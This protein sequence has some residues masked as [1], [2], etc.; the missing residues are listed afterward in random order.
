MTRN[1]TIYR[2]GTAR[3]RVTPDEPLW[4]AGYS[5]RT[6]PARGTLSEL[7]AAA[8]ALQDPEGGTLVIAS[9]DLIAVTKPLAD[10]VYELVA[11]ETGLPRERIV[12]AATHT[13]YGPEFRPDKAV[14]F[15]IPPEFAA[16]IEPTAERMAAALAR[17]IV[18]ALREMEPATLRAGRA[19]AGFA[20]NRRRQGVKFGAPSA[21]DVL[22][23]DVPA[24]S[25]ISED[26]GRQLA[27]VY[28]YACHNTTIPPDDGRYC[29][30][31]AGFAADHLMGD[32]GFPTPLFVAGCGAD[33]NPEPRGSLELSRRYGAELAA[34]ARAALTSDAGHAITGPLRAAFEDVSLPLQPVRRP[35]L[36]Q[37]LAD[38]DPPKRVKA[39]FLLEQLDR[40]ASLI[41]S[42][43]APV[44]AVRIGN[45]LLMIA[46]SGEPVV[47]WSIRFKREFADVAPLVWVAGY[48]ND[49][50][51]YVPTRRIQR[52]GGY[53]G[54][55]ANLW[56]SVPAPFT[57]EVEDAVAAAVS[58]VVGRVR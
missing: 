3:E 28:G 14:F 55:R 19:A 38:D 4:L 23:Q 15:N 46:M 45:E 50:F 1:A 48:C 29:G 51:G 37:M 26:K 57:E 31:W 54:G 40:G 27:I 32:P 7:Y 25:V 58:R 47:D 52:E 43:A 56:S 36:E 49:M 10:R 8:L 22:D 42:Y 17:V 33:Q 5:V 16:K 44:Q 18:A 9:I 2:A 13:H 11:R 21:E 41:T 12:L 24:L 53:E 34:A 20:H 39:K 30:D 6:A 35:D